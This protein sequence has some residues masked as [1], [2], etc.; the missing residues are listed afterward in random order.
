MADIREYIIIMSDIQNLRVH[1][2]HVC[3]AIQVGGKMSSKRQ[4][5]TGGSYQLPPTAQGIVPDYYNSLAEWQQT[6]TAAADQVCRH[7]FQ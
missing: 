7:R 2:E 3:N 5:Q 4:I 1:A 6:I